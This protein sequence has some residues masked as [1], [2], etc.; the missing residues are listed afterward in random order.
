MGAINVSHTDTTMCG[1]LNFWEL[2]Q[3]YWNGVRLLKAFS[4]FVGMP[5]VHGAKG[6]IFFF[7]NAL[8]V[9]KELD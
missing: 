3:G 9:I 4:D 5:S 2:H 1:S 8:L 6:V 7:W